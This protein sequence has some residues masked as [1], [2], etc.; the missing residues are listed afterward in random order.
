MRCLPS[1][2]ARPPN[3]SRLARIYES[4]LGPPLVSL[5][6]TEGN[7]L[8]LPEWLPSEPRPAD[9]PPHVHPLCEVME[10]GRARGMDKEISQ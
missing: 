1:G 4:R 7:F 5:A 6:D 2:R 3:A 8:P 9:W 10:H